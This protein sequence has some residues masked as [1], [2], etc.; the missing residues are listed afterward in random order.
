MSYNTINLANTVL[1]R[2]FTERVPIT[3][4]K[5]QK[6]L[7]FLN[8][9]YVKRTG[10]MLQDEPFLRWKYGPVA[11]S[12]WAEFSSFRANPITHMGADAQGNILILDS[13]A[14]RTFRECF[15]RVWQATKSVDGGWLSSITH[16]PG[17]A[18]IKA[19]DNSQE[20]LSTVDIKN[21]VSYLEPL[22]LLS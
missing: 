21:D 4:M 7:Y 12:V 2:A 1:D 11:Y 15:E 20:V 17:S 6:I 3:P 8:A 18:W 22:G 5:L 13:S 16:F 10:R 19:R 14:D 9:E